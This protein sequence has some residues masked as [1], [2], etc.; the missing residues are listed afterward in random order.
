[1]PFAEIAQAVGRSPAA[2]RQLA[3]RARTH[4]EAGVPRVAATPGQHDA[5]VGAFFSAAAGGDL[6][7]LIATLD[8]D[9]VLTSDGGGFVSAARRPVVGAERVARFLQ[10]TIAKMTEEASADF[11]TINGELGIGIFEGDLLT[12]A[13]VITLDGDRVKRLDMIRSPGKLKLAVV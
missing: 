7:S 4:V 13:V 3:S 11:V 9:V 5:V 8:P 6:Q 1:M 12:T 10:G 2:V